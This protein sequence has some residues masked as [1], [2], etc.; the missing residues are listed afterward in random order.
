MASSERPP[1]FDLDPPTGLGQAR[2]VATSRLWVI[3]RD[4]H[5]N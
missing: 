5:V 2:G 3:K 1:G 4:S